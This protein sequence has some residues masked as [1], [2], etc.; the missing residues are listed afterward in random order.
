MAPRNIHATAIVVE[1]VG[2]LFV[3][4][5][6]IGK[7]AMALQCLAAAK[8]SGWGA[9]LVA[10]DQIFISR[11]GD[12][13][14]ASRPASIAGLLEIRG[15][16]IAH[17]QSI[18]EAVLHLAVLL[19]DPRITDRL[20]AADEICELGEIGLLPQI[21]LMNDHREPLAA[22]AALRPDLGIPTTL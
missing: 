18:P 16:G 4:P 22:I 6:G 15:S 8:R 3:G 20:P 7:S 11:R 2:L 1:D 5:S 13:L 12:Q 17:V 10:D 14:I 19:V 21:R 9:S